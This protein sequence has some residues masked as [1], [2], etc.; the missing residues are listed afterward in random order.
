MDRERKEINT[1][2]NTIEN[3]RALGNRPD[4]ELISKK[5]DKYEGLLWSY[6]HVSH[7][8]HLRRTLDQFYYCTLQSTDRLD[9]N[10]IVSRHTD[11]QIP[12]DNKI[13]LMVDQMWLWV[14]DT[15]KNVSFCCHHRKFIL[16]SR[17]SHHELS[18]TQD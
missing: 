17:H 15:S 1:I 12:N 18:R 6:L 7:P 4:I 14:L 5:D 13:I 10:Q 8:L 2:V 3:S 9:E 16:L 11:G